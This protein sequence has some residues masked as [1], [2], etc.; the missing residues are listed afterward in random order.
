MTTVSNAILG[1]LI[2]QDLLL[3]ADALSGTSCDEQ[4]RLLVTLQMELQ[5]DL[6]TMTIDDVIARAED[7]RH[8]QVKYQEYIL[9]IIGKKRR[10]ALDEIIEERGLNFR[11]KLGAFLIIVS[12][13]YIICLTWLPVPE[14]NQRFAD[15]S[16]GFILATV[17]STIINFF[18]GTSESN[19]SQIKKDD[20][21]SGIKH[22][23]PKHMG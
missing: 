15:T 6:S 16:L 14:I 2:S 21:M 20:P 7:L 23:K 13:I 9:D 17:I 1:A 18:Y 3:L 11:Q 8:F 5:V 4:E 10:M 22:I 19:R 12:L